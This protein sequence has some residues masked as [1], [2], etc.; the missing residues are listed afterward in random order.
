MRI[1][2]D[3]HGGKMVASN[4]QNTNGINKVQSVMRGLKER[5]GLELSEEDVF[6]WLNKGKDGAAVGEVLN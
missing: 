6:S 1:R 2:E 3:S 5:F 4:L